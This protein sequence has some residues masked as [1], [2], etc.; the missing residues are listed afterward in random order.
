VTSQ[1]KPGRGWAYTGAL[2]GGA[3]SVAAK[4]AYSYVP[5]VGEA[6]GW[7]PMWVRWSTLG[8]S[9]PSLLGSPR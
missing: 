1:T 8:V 2:L 6:A 3:V 4:V 7:T 5:P 9:P